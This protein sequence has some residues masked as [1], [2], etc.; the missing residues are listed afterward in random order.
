MNSEMVKSGMV[1][2]I[3][4]EKADVADA[5]MAVSWILQPTAGAL[6]D[7]RGRESWCG[8]TG[9]EIQAGDHWNQPKR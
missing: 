7:E 1:L 4:R 9:K 5:D 2:L 6:V 8:V 3:R